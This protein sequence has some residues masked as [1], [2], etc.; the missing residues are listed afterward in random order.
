MEKKTQGLPFFTLEQVLALRNAPFIEPHAWAVAY[1]A[2]VHFRDLFR[3]RASMTFSRCDLSSFI[4]NA[5]GS[6]VSQAVVKTEQS[7]SSSVS[8]AQEIRI[9]VDGFLEA[10]G[11]QLY[12]ALCLHVASTRKVA[13]RGF[14]GA[15]QIS[16]AL[17]NLLNTLRFQR[18]DEESGSDSDGSDDGQKARRT[19]FSGRSGHGVDCTS[20]LHICELRFAGCQFDMRMDERSSPGA[21]CLLKCADV[22][23]HYINVCRTLYAEALER[24]RADAASTEAPSDKQSA[25]QQLLQRAAKATKELEDSPTDTE[26]ETP[27]HGSE[28]DDAFDDADTLEIGSNDDDDERRSVASSAFTS[29]SQLHNSSRARMT[30]TGSEFNYPVDRR[31]VSFRQREN[32]ANNSVENSVGNSPSKTFFARGDPVRH[33]FAASATAEKRL[34]PNVVRNA[35]DGS[36]VLVFDRRSMPL[37]RSSLQVASR[38]D[39]DSSVSGTSRRLIVPSPSNVAA[40]RDG[41]SQPTEQNTPDDNKL[42][43]P[44]KSAVVPSEGRT[45]NIPNTSSANETSRSQ[46]QNRVIPPPTRLPSRVAQKASNSEAQTA[47]LGNRSATESNET[48][49]RSRNVQRNEPRRPSAPFTSRSASGSASRQSPNRP[50]IHSRLRSIA[51]SCLELTLEEIAYMQSVACEAE[52]ESLAVNR[53]LHAAVCNRTVCFNCLKTRFGHLFDRG[54]TCRV[55]MQKVCD[56]CSTTLRVPDSPNLF[57]LPVF[58]LL[59][60]SVVQ[61]LRPPGVNDAESLRLS[62]SSQLFELNSERTVTQLMLCQSCHRVIVDSVQK[63][64][65]ELLALL[66]KPAKSS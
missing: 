3:G 57:A 49:D 17:E 1:Q 41:L 61:R 8:N 56:R 24:M 16:P 31:A 38:D 42:A 39:A 20:L 11:N 22:R 26:N 54:S 66:Q 30:K 33:S 52:L 50:E 60:S 65:N 25:R 63:C 46:S 37:R 35:G 36:S 47:S 53:Q 6:V 7:V 15:P 18:F 21:L 19:T 58:F 23:E 10:L 2:L 5:N 34:R 4:L 62:R 12:D 32:P 9:G 29:V 43:L 55:C 64:G 28:R 48:T 51:G 40:I 27:E 44:S 45:R 13:R 14:S 59:E